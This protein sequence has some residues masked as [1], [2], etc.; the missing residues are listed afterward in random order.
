M[1]ELNDPL[2]SLIRSQKPA[3]LEEAESLIIKEE[4]VAYLKSFKMQQQLS[5]P[6]ISRI[7][8]RQN[9]FATILDFEDHYFSR[10][11]FC[12]FC[13]KKGHL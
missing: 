8:P 11:K 4:N 7:I 3:T 1:T 12:T 10:R 13:K 2:G 5:K 9:Y 6:S